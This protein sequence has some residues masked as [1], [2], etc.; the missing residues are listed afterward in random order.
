MVLLW[1]APYESRFYLPAR[2]GGK[3]P[4]IILKPGRNTATMLAKSIGG[5]GEAR[6]YFAKRPEALMSALKDDA[7]MGRKVSLKLAEFVGASPDD[8]KALAW[9][10]SDTN[11]KLEDALKSRD[12]EFQSGAKKAELIALLEAHDETNEGGDGEASEGDAS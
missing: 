9:S 8:D 1:K 3:S 4:W 2:D 6:D 10:P 5:D 11:A 7:R 12:V